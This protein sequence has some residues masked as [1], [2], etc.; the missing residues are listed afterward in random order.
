MTRIGLPGRAA[1]AGALLGLVVVAVF[2]LLLVSVVDLRRSSR[3]ARHSEQV[4]ATSNGLE[5][6]LVDLETG[7]RGFV[8]TG[9]DRFLEPWRSGLVAF[10]AD[11]QRLEGLVADNPAQEQRARA[12]AGAGNSYIANY[13]RPLVAQAQHAREAARSVIA[14]ARGKRLVDAIRARFAEFDAVERQLGDARQRTTARAAHRAILFG[15]GGLAATL[16]LIL[17]FV[18]YVVRSIARPVRRVA[19]ASRGLARGD[20]STRVE[21]RGSGEVAELATSFNTMAGSLEESRDELESQNAELELQTAELEDQQVQLAA[22]NDELEAQQAELS[23]AL[24][25]VASEK[26]RVET[27][28]EFGELLVAET[29]APHLG[30]ILLREIADAANAEVATLYSVTAE[31]EDVYV[32][33]AAR[34]LDGSRLDGELRP[35]GGLAGRALAEG[36]TVR[37]SHAETGLT[38]R[39][40]GDEVALRHELHVPL[41]SGERTLGVLTLGRLVDTPFEPERVELIEHLAGQAAVALAGT[42]AFARLS[43]LL[44]F[45]DALLDKTP[46]GIQ[47]IDPDGQVLLRNA[48]MSGLVGDLG[49]IP[50]EGPSFYDRARA[51]EVGATLTDPEGYVAWVAEL[52]ANPDAELRHEFKHAASGR[53]LE[54]FSA[55]V[56]R[57]GERPDARLIV[58]RDV[59]AEREAEQLKNELV[60]TVSHELR[61]PLASILG[62]AELLVERDYDADTRS[63]FLETIRSEARRLSALVSEFLDVQRIEAGLFTLDLQPFELDELLREGATVFSAQSSEHEL[64]L[65]L[66]DEPLTVIGERD[67]IM[68]VLANLLSNAIKYSPGGGRVTVSAKPA[69]RRVR[70]AVMDEGLGIPAA[71]QSQIFSKFFRVDSSE[72]SEIGGT[73]LGL[74]L[75]KEI[76]ERHGGRIGFDSVEGEGTTF[77]F[78]LPV[79]KV[80]EEGSGPLVLVV[81]DDPAAAD[82]VVA[83]LELGDYAVEV[84]ATGEDALERARRSRPAVICLDITLAGDLDGWDV[85]GALKAD[86]ET[87]SIPIL[88][89]TG[90]NGRDNAAALGASD[91]LTK[92]FSAK[93]LRDALVRLLPPAD[94]NVLA[95]D[96][97][98]AVRALITEALAEIGVEVREA[99]DGEEALAK[100]AARNPDA[101]VLDLV[102]PRVDGFEVLE[103]LQSDPA[104]R[105]IPVIVLTARRLSQKERN[106]LSSRAVALLMKSAYSGDE[107]RRLVREAVGR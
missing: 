91:F 63:R 32:L 19:L 14:T 31:H 51:E 93:R 65:E 1:F 44:S 46:L 72:T 97:D 53:Q 104:T 84:T 94:G 92:P 78:E 49:D 99:A 68:Q 60:A 39:A 8:L 27:F 96:D 36:R 41:R 40:L 43:T 25:E 82:L 26:Q 90:G 18:G 75:T 101:I 2:V 24:A 77:W 33:V 15:V 100:V 83:E 64:E 30:D 56:Y 69:G 13:S 98:P 47:L 107:L 35:G 29:E 73:G 95:V 42:I 87:A 10:P 85:L 102:M 38:V 57:D 105:S 54:I 7:A 70:V 81:E 61:T 58:V 48:V 89:C 88:V 12:I 66:P 59:T 22:A 86:P 17:L 67:R 5:K 3:L 74:A 52:A 55:P 28:Y 21:E 16:L 103:R 62:F 45:N 106:Q 20:L 34:G 50:E 76:V 79:T 23:R 37:A 4:L 11:A 9:Q 80:R 71:Q 6:T